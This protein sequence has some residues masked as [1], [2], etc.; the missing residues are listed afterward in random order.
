MPNN[1]TRTAYPPSTAPVSSVHTVTRLTVTS[2]PHSRWRSTTTS[3]AT[4]RNACAR[5]T[6]SAM[7]STDAAGNPTNTTGTNAMLKNS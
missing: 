1:Q 4:G 6:S 7:T 3:S 2:M 5:I